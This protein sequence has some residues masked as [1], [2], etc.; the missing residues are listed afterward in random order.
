VIEQREDG[1]G[2]LPSQREFVK[3][4]I[5]QKKTQKQFNKINTNNHNNRKLN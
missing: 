5:K 1:G 4:Q 3:S 2:G